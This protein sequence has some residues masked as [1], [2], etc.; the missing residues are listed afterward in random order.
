MEKKKFLVIG[1][2]DL[3]IEKFRSFRA[4]ERVKKFI[5]YDNIY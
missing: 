1:T 2:A 3:D 5:Q 4:E